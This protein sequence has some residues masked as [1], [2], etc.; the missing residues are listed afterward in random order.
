MKVSRKWVPACDKRS[1]TV[2]IDDEAADFAS[3]TAAESSTQ[4][5]IQ[6]DLGG[7][8]K[9]NNV[10]IHNIRTTKASSVNPATQPF[11]THYDTSDPVEAAHK[12]M[13]K[14]NSKQHKSA[15]GTYRGM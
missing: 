7:A 8:D 11:N 1:M 12:E 10:L 6:G 4:R 13:A 5:F 15:H 3:D 9:F 14:Q 2:E